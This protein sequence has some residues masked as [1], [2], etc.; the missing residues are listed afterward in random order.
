MATP[1]VRAQP[2]YGYLVEFDDQGSLLAA[3]R[4]V[5][6]KGYQVVEAYS[7][8]PIHGLADIL[9]WKNHLPAIV[10]A[11]GLVG[12]CVGFGLQYWASVIEYP[13]SVGGKP[14]NSWPAFIVP[15]FECTILFAAASAVFGM[16]WLNGLPQPYHPVF[17]VPHFVEAS[18]DK[19]FLM[20]LSRDPSFDMAGTKKFLESLAPVSLE[21]VPH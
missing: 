1:L 2:I 17:N 10:F 12:A 9:G 7:P 21:E 13:M 18:R 5:K 14:L 3:A 6:D 20:I 4:T 15:T 11:G 16:L 19:F 8:L